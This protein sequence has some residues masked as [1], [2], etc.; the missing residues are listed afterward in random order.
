MNTFSG[1]VFNAAL[2]QPTWQ[3]TNGGNSHKAVDGSKNTYLYGGSCT[4]TSDHAAHSW[5][6]VD[7]AEELYLISVRITNREGFGLF[8]FYFNRIYTINETK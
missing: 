6:S 3:S 2:N 4:H 5:F 1:T 7:L 8:I